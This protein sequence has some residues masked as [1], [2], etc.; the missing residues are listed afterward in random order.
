MSH[1]YASANASTASPLYG[2]GLI[3]DP[4]PFRLTLLCH[5]ERVLVSTP[6]S[7]NPSQ[8][9][10][11]SSTS[12]KLRLF[13]TNT[14]DILRC[15]QDDTPGVP[16]LPP[17]HSDRVCTSTSELPMLDQGRILRSLSS[18]LRLFQINAADILRFAQDDKRVVP[19]SSRLI[20]SRQKRGVALLGVSRVARPTRGRSPRNTLRHINSLA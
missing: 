16:F 14:A 9:G 17:C 3:Q 2:E 7:P 15:A 8:R 10:I 1:K 6:E 20:L 18:T 11:L 19:S 13:Q 12:S 4:S 5:S